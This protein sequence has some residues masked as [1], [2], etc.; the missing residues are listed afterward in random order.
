MK[1]VKFERVEFAGVEGLRSRLERARGPQAMRV[2]A[3]V[4][5]VVGT[6]SA[7]FAGRHV[8]PCS[9]LEGEQPPGPRHTFEFVFAAV[10]ELETRAR[11]E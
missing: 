10:G 4:E 11:H 9:S 2:A 7:R 3:H 6:P 1:L 5:R 8:L